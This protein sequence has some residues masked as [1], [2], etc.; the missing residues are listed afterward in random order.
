MSFL[1]YLRQLRTSPQLTIHPPADPVPRVIL[2]FLLSPGCANCLSL[3]NK[4]A[5]FADGRKLAFIPATVCL[6]V[7]RDVARSTESGFEPGYF[8]REAKDPSSFVL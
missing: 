8:R 2:F 6:A 4:L 7:N 1:S 5:A 3:N